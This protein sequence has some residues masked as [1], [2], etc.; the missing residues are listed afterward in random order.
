[1]KPLNVVVGLSL[2]TI[3]FHFMGQPTLSF[4][5][6]LVMIFYTF[7]VHKIIA[8]L[9]KPKPKRVKTLSESF[10]VSYVELCKPI[11]YLHETY[12]NKNDAEILQIREAEMLALLDD[13]SKKI[14][15]STHDKNFKVNAYYNFSSPKELVVKIEPISEFGNIFIKSFMEMEMK[16]K[17]YYEE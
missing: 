16:R 15:K 3:L 17:A 4:I 10:Q 14:A 12:P 8:I 5:S 6:C 2:A 13:A 9:L 11:D 1:M 7:N